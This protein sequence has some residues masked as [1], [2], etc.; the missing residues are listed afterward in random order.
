MTR[1]AIIAAATLASFVCLCKG[2]YWMMVSLHRILFIRGPAFMGGWGGM[3]P[4]DI[5]SALTSTPSYM[6][7]RNPDECRAVIDR[8]AEANVLGMLVICVLLMVYH[9][10]CVLVH[11]SIRRLLSLYVFAA[12]ENGKELCHRDTRGQ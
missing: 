12:G 3:D 9:A 10:S 2:A 8:R 11:H 4:P 1:A 5:C 6:W 7:L